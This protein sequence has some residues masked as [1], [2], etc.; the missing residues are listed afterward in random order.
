MLEHQAYDIRTFAK[1]YGIS[2]SQAYLEIKSGRLAIFKVGRR[3]L[4]SRDAAEIWRRRL[5]E[6]RARSLHA[7]ADSTQQANISHVPAPDNKP[8][9]A[10]AESGKTIRQRV[11]RL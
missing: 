10:G 1:A 11:E 2:R 7:P 5:E 8:C 6:E 9:V 3:T 4:I